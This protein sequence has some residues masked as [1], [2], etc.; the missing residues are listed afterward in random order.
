M[1]P[2]TLPKNCG[3][4]GVKSMLRTPVAVGVEIDT[5]GTF[6]VGTVTGDEPICGPPVVGPL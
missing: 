3:L 5:E 4:P 1:D 2:G 6:G